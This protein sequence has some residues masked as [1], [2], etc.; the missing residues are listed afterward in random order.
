MNINVVD[1]VGSLHMYT[2]GP[3]LH[4]GLLCSA[5]KGNKS[6]VQIPIAQILA[7]ISLCYSTAVR[8]QQWQKDGSKYLKLSCENVAASKRSFMRRIVNQ[9]K[10]VVFRPTQH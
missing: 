1:L 10:I 7:V 3:S 6:I 9:C 2:Q 8:G 5:H 4:H